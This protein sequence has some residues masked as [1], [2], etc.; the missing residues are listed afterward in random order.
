MDKSIFL[1]LQYCSNTFCWMI[2]K[3]CIYAINSMTGSN[4]TVMDFFLFS[5][6]KIQFDK[7]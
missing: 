7:W 2:H 6:T 3:F 4:Y 5:I 1:I